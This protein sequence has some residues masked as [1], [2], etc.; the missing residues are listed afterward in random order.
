LLY[1][2]MDKKQ[3]MGHFKGNVLNV[4]V[5]SVLL[6]F[7]YW[8]VIYRFTDF[9]GLL[10]FVA[11]AFGSLGTILFMRGFAKLLGLLASLFKHKS[12]KGLHTF[13]LRQ[14]QENIA[15]KSTS[16]AVTSILITL[17]IILIADGASTFIGFE[18]AFT[19]NSSLYDFTI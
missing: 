18:S 5:G 8:I 1:E 3:N 12:N 11:A 9:A 15:N 7:A 19:R 13:T 2:Q 16:V 6:G 14:F 10:L 17:S 4:L